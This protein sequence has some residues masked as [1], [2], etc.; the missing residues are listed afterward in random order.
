MDF[1]SVLISFTF[2]MIIINES[3]GRP[4][5]YVILFL[6]NDDSIIMQIKAHKKL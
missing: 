1:I 2:F 6:R 3:R 4:I 5:G